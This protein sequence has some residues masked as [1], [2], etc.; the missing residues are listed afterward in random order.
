[1]HQYRFDADPDPAFHSDAIQIR[2]LP[3]FFFAYCLQQ[4]QSSLFYLSRRRQSGQ[5]FQYFG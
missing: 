3:E 4:S 5:N 2:I 1:M